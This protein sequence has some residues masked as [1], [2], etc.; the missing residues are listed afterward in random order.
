MKLLLRIGI[1]VVLLVVVAA[2]AGFILIDNIA[3]AAVQK[4][5]AFATQTDVTVEKVDVAVFGSNAQIINLDIANP[6][7]EFMKAIEDFPEEYKDV[8]NSF[9]ILGNG[10]AQI[11]V[12]KVMADKIEIDKVE[13]SDIT[14]S[15][16]AKDGVK[17]YEVILKSLK[18][19]QGDTPPK[20]TEDQKEVVIKELIIRNIT[21]YY[22]F[23][24]DPA[25]GAIA[26]GPKKIMMAVDEPMVLTDVGSGGVPMSQI[27]ADIITDVMVQVTANL[28]GDIGD[29]VL[30]L[31]GSLADTIGAGELKA[32]LGELGLD[33]DVSKQ[34]G[35]LKDL[36]VDIGS[37]AGDVIKGAGDL[38]G[39]G[40]GGILGGDKDKETNEESENKEDKEDKDK[41]LLDDINPF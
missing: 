7:G 16:L 37:G 29:H 34:L 31:T 10:T 14:I 25:L 33:L 9:L 24:E 5:A 41:S 23:D 36:G 38:I 17:N 40:I 3:T 32:T 15:L 28:A 35:K 30:G 2:V 4:G 22:Y 1:V 39:G 20:E 21:V 12:G 19:F 27:T 13:L 11:T 6:D 18:R 26:V 8:F